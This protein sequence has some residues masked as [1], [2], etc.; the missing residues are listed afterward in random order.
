MGERK[1]GEFIIEKRQRRVV[2]ECKKSGT[3]Y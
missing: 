3:G 2:S 1:S